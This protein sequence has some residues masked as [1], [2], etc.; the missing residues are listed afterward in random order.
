MTQR[1]EA[2]SRATKLEFTLVTETSRDASTILLEDPL[3]FEQWWIA[4]LKI[5]KP[6]AIADQLAS[7]GSPLAMVRSGQVLGYHPTVIERGTM[8]SRAGLLSDDPVVRLFALLRL[9]TFQTSLGFT[10]LEGELFGSPTAIPAV[11]AILEAAETLTPQS[12]LLIEVKARSH[13]VLAEAHW[14]EGRNEIAKRHI[15]QA[16]LMA[17]ALGLKAA[18]QK[19]EL[20][21][22]QIYFDSGQV[23]MAREQFKRL[24]ED[25]NTQVAYAHPSA[26]MVGL[27]HTAVGDDDAAIQWCDQHLS[28]GSHYEALCG[29]VRA[30]AGVGGL[31]IPLADY[32]RN[33]TSEFAIQYQCRQLV[34]ENH[35]QPSVH[36]MRKIQ[37][38][39]DTAR[40]GSKW[41]VAEFAWFKCYA[42]YRLGEFGLVE[43]YFPKLFDVPDE[44][45]ALRC[46]ILALSI[47]I[48]VAFNG[49]DV[50]PPIETVQTLHDI[51]IG[52]PLGA[53]RGIARRI[54]L[55]LPAAGAFLA[56]SPYS[57]PE[58]FEWCGGAVMQVRGKTLVHRTKKLQ[59]IH[60]GVVT[61][62]DFGLEFKYHPNK[63]QTSQVRH[64]M[65]LPCGDRLHWH[66]AISPALLVHAY[67]RMHW[68]VAGSSSQTKTSV[69][70]QNA[71][72]LLHS[73]GL[74][75]RPRGFEIEKRHR[76]ESALGLLVTK[77]I[78][79]R[80]VQRML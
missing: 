10:A 15:A 26:V 78:H 30:V 37:Q 47:E 69:W 29:Y 57:T 22:Y 36:A 28:D 73:H 53:R 16:L 14:L 42:A 46:M 8:C 51:L 5:A 3:G 9:A 54:A 72:A 55:L 39:C 13:T 60:S 24:A 50:L 62:A 23:L 63:L 75:S 49:R 1:H 6:N 59:P 7:L 32:V 74:V 12:L 35:G 61:L 66:K 4:Q 67:F 2:V 31:E 21:Q 45:T 76:L 27:A 58:L 38:L 48:S 77:S 34:L 19:M 44:Q 64:A 17:D 68:L 25:P 18:K 70:E 79:P 33:F 56:Y 40:T 43:Q 65:L 80:E 71:L 52:L 11:E 41:L 20:I